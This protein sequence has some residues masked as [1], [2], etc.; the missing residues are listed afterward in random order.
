MSENG[1][2]QKYGKLHTELHT[3]SFYNVTCSPKNI[4]TVCEMGVII[5]SQR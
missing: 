1:T 5:V 4:Y 3:L 2:K